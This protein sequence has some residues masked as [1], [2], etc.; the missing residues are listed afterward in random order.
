MVRTAEKKLLEK[1][2]T[3][4]RWVV[5]VEGMTPAIVEDVCRNLL[6]AEH[7]ARHG[8]APDLSL[9]LYRLVYSLGR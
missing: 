7:L 9:A 8:A 5:M 1:P 4:V 3:L 2:D 6:E